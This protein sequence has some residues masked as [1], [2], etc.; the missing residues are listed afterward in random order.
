MVV[1]TSTGGVKDNE[2]KIFRE[3]GGS[4]EFTEGWARNALKGTDWVKRKG[5]TVKVNLVPNF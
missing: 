1:A 4:L 5:M 3:F 2:P